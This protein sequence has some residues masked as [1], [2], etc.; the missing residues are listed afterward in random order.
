MPCV[1]QG[2]E[3][4]GWGG[5]GSRDTG[6]CHLLLE[7]KVER[8]VLGDILCAVSSRELPA[9]CVWTWSNELPQC[10]R[11]AA[12]G[13]LVLQ[14]WTVGIGTAWKHLQPWSKLPSL[15]CSDFSSYHKLLLSS[16]FSLSKQSWVQYSLCWGWMD[17]L[18]SKP[19]FCGGKSSAESPS[20]QTMVTAACCPV[21]PGKEESS[22]SL[23]SPL[24]CLC[25]GRC[26]K[27]PRLVA[28]AAVGEGTGPV[29]SGAASAGACLLC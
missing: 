26:R 21:P 25:C 4:W 20:P 16:L 3:G 7:W 29:G 13:L 10:S 23:W 11:A 12:S 28:W 17:P 22:S 1:R 27:P 14:L 2:R 19:A 6:C 5:V 9:W 8:W 18:Y 15:L 24:V